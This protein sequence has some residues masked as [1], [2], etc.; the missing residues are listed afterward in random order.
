M[1]RYIAGLEQKT[2]MQLERVLTMSM[3]DANYERE[4]LWWLKKYLKFNVNWSQFFY[5][6][7]MWNDDKAV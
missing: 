5:S 6:I 4:L 7:F 2:Y 3:G 1:Q